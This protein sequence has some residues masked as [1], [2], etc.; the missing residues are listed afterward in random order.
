MYV[1][2]GDKDEINSILKCHLANLMFS[3]CLKTKRYL[4]SCLLFMILSVNVYL[5]LCSS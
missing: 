3:Y 4:E 5:K 1:K 2:R